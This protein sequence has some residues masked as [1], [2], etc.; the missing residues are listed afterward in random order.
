ADE[1]MFRAFNMGIGFCLVVPPASADRVGALLS[2]H[3]L[4]V[5]VLGRATDDA[6]RTIALRP[7]NLVSRDGRFA[8]VT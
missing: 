5:H 1:E 7:Q 8:R 2:E 6:E 4:T 3:G